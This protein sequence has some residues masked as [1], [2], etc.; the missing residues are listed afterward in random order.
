[1]AP[2]PVNFHEWVKYLPLVPIPRD[3]AESSTEEQDEPAIKMLGHL[4]S[5]HYGRSGRILRSSLHSRTVAGIARRDTDARFSRLLRH[6]APQN[7]NR[8]LLI[9]FALA[10]D[11]SV[12]IL[13]YVAGSVA[14]VHD[15]F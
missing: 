15:Q 9:L 2:I 5:L 10:I 11:D 3:F 14:G 7:R 12:A 13:L 1:M 8:K 6:V 4:D